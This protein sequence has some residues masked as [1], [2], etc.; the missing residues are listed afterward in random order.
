MCILRN[1]GT[2]E[3]KE[4]LWGISV[5]KLTR[6]VEKS[7]NVTC[8]IFYVCTRK[9][10]NTSIKHCNTAIKHCNT[11]LF[12]GEICHVNSPFRSHKFLKKRTNLQTIC[13][14]LRHTNKSHQ[15]CLFVDKLLVGP[16]PRP[17]PDRFVLLH[18]GK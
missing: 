6:L 9:Q 13:I 7:S 14:A 11:S 12:A 8:G 1:Q 10:S 16:N 3:T 15:R 18:T 4:A 2:F 17:S 5:R